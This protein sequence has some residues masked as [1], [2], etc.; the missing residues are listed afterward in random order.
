MRRKNSVRQK[1]SVVEV[2]GKPFLI[3]EINFNYARWFGQ[4]TK[5][6]FGAQ[7]FFYAFFMHVM[8]IKNNP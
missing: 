6:V 1:M 2:W 8:H 3:V 7:N 4:S 5:L